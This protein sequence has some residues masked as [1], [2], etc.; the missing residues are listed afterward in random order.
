MYNSLAAYA[1]K[2]EQDGDISMAPVQ[3]LHANSC[4][5]LML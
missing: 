4:M 5:F 1:L 2:L 3:R